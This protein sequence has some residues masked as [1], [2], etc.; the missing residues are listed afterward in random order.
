MAKFVIY[1]IM[2]RNYFLT[3][4]QRYRVDSAVQKMHRL[5]LSTNPIHVNTDNWASGERERVRERENEWNSRWKWGLQKCS[6]QKQLSLPKRLTQS[7]TERKG[8]THRHRESA[9]LPTRK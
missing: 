1:L 8:D 9:A 2:H 5:Q 4:L 6:S 3:L 7:A